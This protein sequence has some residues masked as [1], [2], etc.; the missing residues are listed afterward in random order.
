MKQDLNT[1]YEELLKQ[2]KELNDKVISVRNMLYEEKVNKAI[3][4]YIGKWV[5]IPGKVW[6]DENEA[7]DNQFNQ[8]RIFHV[9]KLANWLGGSEVLL[10]VSNLVCISD[11]KKDNEYEVT[12]GNYSEDEYK[13]ANICNMKILTY[14][15]LNKELE[16]IRKF[17]NKQFDKISKQI[18][19]QE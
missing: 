14:T 18:E 9:D 8:Y 10:K 5:K 15:Q 13:V 1:Q 3:S 19:K 16:K 6:I 11:S 17:A 12:F 7:Y 4:P 2:Q